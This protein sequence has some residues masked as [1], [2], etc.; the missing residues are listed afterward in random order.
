MKVVDFEQRVWELEHLRIVVRSD[1][2]D[3]VEDYDYK[4]AANEN[5]RTA[6]FVKNRVV[7][8]VGGREVTVIQ[9]DGKLAHGN[10][11]LYALRK[12]YFAK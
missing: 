11:L 12:S 2:Q 7:G 8:R 3:E 4:N 1:R 9:G 5:W 6:E 10:V